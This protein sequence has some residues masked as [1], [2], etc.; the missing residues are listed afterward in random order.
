[1][2]RGARD[3]GACR[4]DAGAVFRWQASK[5]AFCCRRGTSRAACESISRAARVRREQSRRRWLR[6]RSVLGETPAH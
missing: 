1:M 5:R 3:R 2:H 4:H 6:A